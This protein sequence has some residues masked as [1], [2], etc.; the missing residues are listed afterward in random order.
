MLHSAL[1][2][3]HAS[4]RALPSESEE[5]LIRNVVHSGVSANF[6]EAL[7]ALCGDLSDDH[8]VELSI[9]YAPALPVKPLTRY[10]WQFRPSERDFLRA[11]GQQ[12]RESGIDDNYHLVGFVHTIKQPWRNDEY[13]VTVL[14]WIRERVTRVNVHLDA[15]HGALAAQAFQKRIPI[16][17][18]GRLQERKQTFL[19]DQ[20]HDVKLY[21]YP[22]DPALEPLKK[23]PVSEGPR[24][25][26]FAESN[27]TKKRRR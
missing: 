15:D 16:E 20:P 11:F 17:C 12:L 24:P 25:L 18:V 26:E 8:S 7:G 2:T 4:H 23:P 3:V 13:L 21:S 6:C 1:E 27:D 5:Q 19:L 10:A 9:S 22:D 14:A